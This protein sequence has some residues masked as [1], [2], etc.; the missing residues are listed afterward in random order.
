[1]P[2]AEAHPGPR[3]RAR[4]IHS[5]ARL[6]AAGCA[7]PFSTGSEHPVA[8]HRTCRQR[9]PARRIEKRALMR[10]ALRR[11]PPVLIAHLDGRGKV[12]EAFGW[13][14]RR[15]EW[16]ALACLHCG[17]FTRARWARL[18]DARPGQLRGGVHTDRAGLGRRGDR[19]RHLGGSDGFVA[20]MP[21]APLPCPRRRGHPPGRV[22]ASKR[23]TPRVGPDRP[24]LR[25]TGLSDAAKAGEPAYPGYNPGAGEGLRPFEPQETRAPVE[26]AGGGVAPLPPVAA[27]PDG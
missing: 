11:P 25:R 8:L 17:V 4:D 7:L 15:A 13:T 3:W 16:I 10:N 27:H 26:F 24:R 21:G 19:A 5:Q 20:S 9:D 14:G 22:G 6:D 1:M 2:V 18:M 23:P 12:L